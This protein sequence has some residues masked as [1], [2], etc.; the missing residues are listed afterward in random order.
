MGRWSASHWKVA[1]FDRLAFVLGFV[2]NGSAIGRRQLDPHGANVGESHRVDRM[3]RGDGFRADP[4]VVEAARY[5]ETGQK[6]ATS[7]SA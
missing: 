2:A 7:C 3:L 6:P 1:V 5:V 4:R